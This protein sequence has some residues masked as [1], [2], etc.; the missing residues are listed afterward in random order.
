[1]TRSH[2]L[3]LIDKAADE[4]QTELDLAGLGLEELPPEIGK[5]TQLETLVLGK[6]NRWRGVDG[7]WTPQPITNKLTSLPEEL[8]SLENLR[9]IDLSCNPFG[10]IP[11]LGS[12]PLFD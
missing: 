2:L 9:S 6:V 7:K 4:G 1:M 5:C 12:I 3:Q 10:T 8:R 11:E